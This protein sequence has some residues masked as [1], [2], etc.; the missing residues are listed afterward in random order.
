MF[1][2]GQFECSG[3]GT[4]NRSRLRFVALLLWLWE[5]LYVVGAE[6]LSKHTSSVST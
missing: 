1:P 2:D 5:L 6:S 4:G 3:F